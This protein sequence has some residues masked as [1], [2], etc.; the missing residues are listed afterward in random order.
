MKIV[1]PIS[2]KYDVVL[3]QRLESGFIINLYKTELGIGVSRYFKKIPR[4]EIYR[5]PATGYRFYFPFTVS[6]DGKFYA[7]LQKVPWYY[8]AWKW[9]HEVAAKLIAPGS[10]VLEIGCGPGAFLKKISVRCPRAVGLE[11]N[12]SAAKKG[13]QEGVKILLENIE[14]HAKNHKGKYD[15]VCLFQVLE[16][17]WEVKKFIDSALICLK[18]NG[19]ILISVPNNDCLIFKK[20][21][22]YLNMPPHHMGLWDIHSLV[23]LQ[24]YF[25]MM[26]DDLYIEPLQLYHQGFARKLLPKPPFWLKNHDPVKVLGDYIVGHTLLASY[27]KI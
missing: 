14:E 9:E 24:K 22:I 18:K 6:G 2:G 13:R 7:R 23:S 17:I 15:V 25:P 12:I 11:Q 26:L 16:H 8:M 5:C 21:D 3:E 19:K 10:S 27:T 20:F 4:V 1:S